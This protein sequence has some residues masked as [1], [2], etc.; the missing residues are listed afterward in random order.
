MLDQDVIPE[1]ELEEIIDRLKYEFDE[2]FG[3]AT[4]SRKEKM[5]AYSYDP[6][7]AK[8]RLVAEQYKEFLALKGFE[9]ESVITDGN[10]IELWADLSFNY[11]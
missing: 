4:A 11:Y 7:S 3:L 8:E 9:V 1:K 10:K 5:L 6:K 2:N